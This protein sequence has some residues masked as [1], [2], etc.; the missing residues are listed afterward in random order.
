MD[1]DKTDMHILKHLQEDARVSFRQLAKKVGVSVPTISARVS[2]LRELGII[3]GYRTDI[4]PQRLN[5]CQIVLLVKCPPSARSEV[6]AAL[7]E[8][9]EVRWV[10]TARG[11]RVIALATVAHQEDIDPLL[12]QVSRVPEV[13]DYEHFVVASV[14]KDLP[15]A[16]IT[17]G[18][19][20]SLICY[21]CKDPIH[22]DP[23]KV[24]M[25]ARDHYFCCHSC[26][27]LYVDRYRRIKAR[28]QA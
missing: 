8:L 1:L 5:E 21:Q 19:S 27:K 11:P 10:M 16:L 2:T 20:A 22:G 28:A 14:V 9:V 7:A 23:I 24:K 4:D 6:A 15:E 13:L 17:D 26:E 12:D 18:L 25:D 3:R